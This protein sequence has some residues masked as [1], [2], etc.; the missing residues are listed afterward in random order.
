MIF[1]IIEYRS[2]SNDNI[3]HNKFVW[4]EIHQNFAFVLHL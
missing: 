3:T 1:E 4:N 2:N